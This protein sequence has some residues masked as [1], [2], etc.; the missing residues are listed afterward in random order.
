MMAKNDKL[1]VEQVHMTS[2]EGQ[3]SDAE[4]KISE[5]II[6]LKSAINDLD[7]CYEGIAT[8]LNRESFEKYIQHLEFLKLCC[9]ANR[10]FIKFSKESL[11]AADKGASGLFRQ[12]FYKV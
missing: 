9:Q 10:E 1:I 2:I 7:A 6:K 3:Y 11:A 5:I 4:K 12:P 8:A